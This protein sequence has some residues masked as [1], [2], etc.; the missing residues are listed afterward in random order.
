[1]PI[2]VTVGKKASEGL[3]EFKLR[4]TD[5]SKEITL[6]EAYQEIL[7]LVKGQ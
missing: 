5:E 2:R 7:H 4:K 1:L 6:E 3:V